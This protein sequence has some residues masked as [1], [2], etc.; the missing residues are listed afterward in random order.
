M[1]P[2]AISCAWATIKPANETPGTTIRNSAS[3]TT[4]VAASLGRTRS[5]QPVVHRG[6]DGVQ[7]RDADEPRGVRRERDDHPKA[8][9]Q[10][11]QRR[12]LMIRV[13]QSHALV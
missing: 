5:G 4:R 13:D 8:Q 11:D 7:D 1:T 3:A 10:D 9:Q 2:P 12:A 6:E